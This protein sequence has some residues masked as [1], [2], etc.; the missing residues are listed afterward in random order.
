MHEPVKRF[1]LSA[2]AGPSRHVVVIGAGPAGL[3]A[4]MQLCRRRV[5]VTV[6]EKD[7]LVGGIART[8]EYKGYHFDI[9]GH[10]FFTKIPEVEKLWN[11]L[12]DGEFLIRPR[13]SRIYYRGRFFD[14]PLRPINAVSNLGLLTSLQVMWSYLQA[15]VFPYLREDTFEEWVCNRFGRKLFD[16]FFRAYTEKVWGLPCSEIR[17]AW[18]AQRIQGLSLPITIKN[19]MFGAPR[20]RMVKT[21]IQQFHYP[22]R[23]PGQMWRAAQN[24]VE[25]HGGCIKLESD[26]VAT[27]CVLPEYKIWVGPCITGNFLCEVQHL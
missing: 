7:M 17:A 2:S 13:T 14:Y 20:E 6:L 16:I 1:Q 23:G 5:R 4:A 26:V 9:G 21:L 12:L 3:T 25:G 18:A 27:F 11:E 22:R 8:G 10:R 24:Y 19:A 15:R